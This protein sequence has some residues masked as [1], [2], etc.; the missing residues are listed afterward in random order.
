MAIIED[1]RSPIPRNSPRFMHQLRAFIRLRNLALKTEQTYC[2]WI[3]RYIKYH[4]FKHPKDMG[5]KHV[6]QFL[7]H[8]AVVDNVAISTQ[9]TA[10]NAMAF[11]YNQ[12]LQQPLGDLN[13][14]PSR[15]PKKVPNVFSASEAFDVIKRLTNPW[16]LAASLMYG[17][18][19][20]VNEVVSLRVNS[21]DFDRKT[22]LV[23]NGKGNKE[24]YTLLP[25][26][27]VPALQRQLAHVESLLSAD[28]ARGVG[29]VFISGLMAR[30]SSSAAYEF[31]WQFLFPSTKLMLDEENHTLR[32]HHIYGRS[33]QRKVKQA[34]QNAGI[35]KRASSHTFRHS[36]A[37]HLLEQGTDIRTVQE[38]LGHANVSTT[39]IYT[40]VLHRGILA[41]PSPLDRGDI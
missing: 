22:I 30:Q 23:Q 32:R 7:H 33:L 18:G 3:K 29:G 14:T 37:T 10:L 36:F 1:I 24:R 12:F 8:L 19:L 39:E 27:A 11:L 2:Q 40:H 28:Q 9:R 6:E 16:G 4:Q 25:D 34:I 5:D 41:T 15:V 35:N 20:R 21:L 38:L 17:A 26:I 13:I 31:G